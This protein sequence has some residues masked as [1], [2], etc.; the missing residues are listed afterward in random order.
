MIILHSKREQEDGGSPDGVNGGDHDSSDQE[1]YYRFN[2]SSLDR[3]GSGSKAK[4][5]V[6]G[7]LCLGKHVKGEKERDHWN[8]MM[9][10]PRKVFTELHTLK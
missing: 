7:I 3:H 10:S 1:S 5:P 2:M 4:D 6:L 9:D 8:K